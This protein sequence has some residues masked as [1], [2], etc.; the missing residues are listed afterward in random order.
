MQAVT[1][2]SGAETAV[3]GIVNAE[4]GLVTTFKKMQGTHPA[5]HHK[6]MDVLRLIGTDPGLEKRITALRAEADDRKRQAL[7]NALPIVVW[8]GEFSKRGNDN[9]TAHA[10]LLV[11]DFD[12]LPPDALATLR[13]QVVAD[14]HT[15]GAFTSPSGNGLKVVVRIEPRPASNEEH[16]HAWQVVADH[17]GNSP[18]PSGKN[19]E[20]ICFLSFDPDVYINEDAEPLEIP[21]MATT[22]PAGK[23]ATA[24]VSDAELAAITKQA[25]ARAL[26]EGTPERPRKLLDKLLEQVGKVDFRD[27]AGL[28]AEDEKLGRKHFLVCAVEEVLDKARANR[29]DLCKN[30]AFI[31]VYNGAFWETVEKEELQTFLGEAAERMGVDKFDARHYVF[32]GQLVQQFHAK[33][34]LPT[35][36]P[37]AEVVQVNLRNGTFEI[38]PKGQR[39]R[40]ASSAD[41]LTYQLPFDFDREATAPMFQAYLDKVQPD[42][43]RQLILAESV[44]HVFINTATLKLEKVPLLYGTGANGKSVFFDVVNALLGGD[45]NV[46]S[47]TLQQLTDENGYFRA[48]LANKLVNYASEINGK[49]D[50]AYF[51]SLASGEPVSARLPYGE[52][53]TVTRY[54]KLMFNCNELPREVEQTDAFFRRFLLI[55]FEVTIPDAEQDRELSG[56]IIGNELSGVFNWVLD[57][58]QRLLRQKRFTQ[59]K[60]VDDALQQ[61][62]TRSDSVRS[63]LEEHGL[64]P[65]VDA[66]KPLKD[67]YTAYVTHCKESGSHPC[68]LRTFAERMRNTGYTI[69]RSNGVR[70]VWAVSEA[71]NKDVF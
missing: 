54:A 33:G 39:L 40:P 58:L 30:A 61:Y 6:A 31:Y 59:S 4:V 48:K 57:G 46:S 32:M 35:P 5:K 27:R 45:T 69:T 51:K 43:V 60:A 28:T 2:E 70:L 52:P 12:K 42:K 19:V 37:S 14:P 55:P 16:A 68:A 18:D 25:L 20:R 21:P 13:A 47:Y 9:L 15:F 23:A 65:S 26:Q 56:K 41:F 44:A 49:M 63:Y 66:H 22:A 29:W 67:I 1:A 62:R 36:E 50:A 53:F 24:G 64:Q 34:H 7:K 38:G 71:E 17:Y 3:G 8:A 10:G 11:L